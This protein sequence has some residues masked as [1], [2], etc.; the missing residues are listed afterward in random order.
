MTDALPD[1]TAYRLHRTSA[2]A[3]LEG[4]AVPGLH[5][6]IFH[7]DLG[8]RVASVGLYRYA[9]RELLM[10]WGFADEE[11]C[12]YSAL[13]DVEGRWQPAVAGCPRV[14]LV[15]AGDRADGPVTGLVLRDHRGRWVDAD[16]M[17]S[18]A[19]WPVTA[20]GYRGRRR[21]THP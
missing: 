21:P 16:R 1:L 8:E 12:R 11:H 19:R 7:R 13:C 6:E 2:D 3:Q 17:A 9:G 15:R 5:A 20:A 14:R 4:A 18:G 10:A